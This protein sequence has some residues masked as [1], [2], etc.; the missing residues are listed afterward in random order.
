[1]IALAS[2]L[3]LLIAAFAAFC[4]RHNISYSDKGECPTCIENQAKRPYRGMNRSVLVDST[5]VRYRPLREDAK[6][7]ALNSK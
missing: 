1:M 2:V 7:S 4:K 5:V 6:N 3:V